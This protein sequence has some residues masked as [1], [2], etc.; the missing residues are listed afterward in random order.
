MAAEFGGKRSDI[1]FDFGQNMLRRILFDGLYSVQA[2]SVHVVL[3]HPVK[4][5][6]NKVT[7]HAFTARLIEIDGFAPGRLMH[8]GEIWAEEAQIITFIAKMVVNHVQA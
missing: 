7:A 6:L 5:V 3:A 2:K 1:G 8:V 4:R